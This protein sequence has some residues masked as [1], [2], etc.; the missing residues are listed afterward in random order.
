MEVK[1]KDKERIRVRERDRECKSKRGSYLKISEP[2]W[3]VCI[4]NVPMAVVKTSDTESIFENKMKEKKCR[5]SA[6]NMVFEHP[7]DNDEL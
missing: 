2:L 6:V 1:E 3:M 7:M 4:Y 5:W